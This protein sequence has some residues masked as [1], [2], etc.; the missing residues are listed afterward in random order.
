M[1]WV[2]LQLP[3]TKRK[4]KKHRVTVFIIWNSWPQWFFFLGTLRYPKTR[5]FRWRNLDDFEVAHINYPN[6]YQQPLNTQ[7]TNLTIISAL[8]PLAQSVFCVSWRIFN[9]QTSA[10]TDLHGWYNEEGKLYDGCSLRPYVRR[11]L[12]PLLPGDSYDFFVILM[13]SN[14]QQSRHL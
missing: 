14:Q 3:Q 10:T 12:F 8:P 9:G 5:G 13:V 2:H 6:F 11:V 7:I 1:S 4:L